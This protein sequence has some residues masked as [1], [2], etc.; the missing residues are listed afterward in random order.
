VHRRTGII[1]AAAVVVG[2][3]TLTG[4]GTGGGPGPGAFTS[5]GP[6]KIWYSNNAQEVTW[7]KQVVASWNKAHPTEQVTGQEIPAGKTSE[8]VIGASITAG[9]APCLIYNT[10]PAAVGQFQKQGGLVDLSKFPGGAAY[11]NSRSGALAKQYQD[12]KGQYYQ[13]P[14]K[15]NPVV[16]FYNKKLFTKAGLDPNHPQLSTYAQFIATS[17]KLVAAKVSQYAILPAPTSEY[18]QSNFDFYP[19][20]AAETG[21]KL[22]I[23]NKKATFDNQAGLDVANFWSTMYKDKLA[24]QEAYQGDAFADGVAAMAI[25]GPW[26]VA[27]YKGKVDWG[28]VPVPTKEGTPASKIWTFSDAKNIGLYSACTHQAT[29]W[30]FLKYSTSKAEDSKLLSM[31]GQMPIRTNLATTYA[32][33]F[34]ANPPYQAFGAQAPRTVEDPPG[35]NAIEELQDFRDAW[36]QSVIFQGGNLKSSLSGAAAKLN[37]I[38]TQP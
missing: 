14:W 34:K 9:N 8:E 21:G 15:S 31:T 7:G 36:S 25:V 13:L 30:D 12:S 24:G 6:I 28:S 38:E 18:F 1:A 37:H 27:T 29:A 22:L 19:L 32:S 16:I 10:A 33:Y 5:R 3:L 26:A 11:I 17:K 20:Y 4:C 2:A 23:K 35:P